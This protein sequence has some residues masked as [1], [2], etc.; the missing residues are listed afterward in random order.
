MKNNTLTKKVLIYFSAA[1]IASF[2][3]AEATA[4][5]VKLYA[6]MSHSNVGF[7]V[8]LAGGLTRI[9]GKYTDFEIVFTYVDSSITKSSIKATIKTASINTGIA[10]RDEHLSNA[11][12]FDAPQYPEITFNSDSI[13][14]SG[15]GY[16]A[17]GTLQLHGVSKKI[18]L[19]FTVVG[20]DAEG[21]I[22]FTS[23]YTL[24][25][26]DFKLGDDAEKPNSYVSN[27]VQ[28]EIDFIA[29]KPKVKN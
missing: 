7:S 17:Y 21:S 16:I 27:E 2:A 28:I 23:R 10:G 12:F 4:Q 6:D 15:N 5:T 11:D 18:Q 20:K 9:T 8:P 1:F 22:G 14:A 19:L 26:S 25:R 29:Q 24:K 13:V 3:T